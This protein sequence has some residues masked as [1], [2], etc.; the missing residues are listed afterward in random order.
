[1]RSADLRLAVFGGDS[2][3]RNRNKEDRFVPIHGTK[4]R[5]LLQSLPRGSELV[6]VM[7]DGKAVSAEELRRYLKRL[8]G[9]CG[10]AKP[11]QY[12][13]HTFRRFFASCCSRQKLSYKYILEWRGHSSG[14]VLDVSFMMNDRQA[15]PAMNSL[16]FD[17]ENRTVP[18]Q[19]GVHFSTLQAQ[20]VAQ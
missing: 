12:K 9:Q 4:L 16:S 18:G 2:N 13:L 20:V 14:G 8:C 17:S 15:Q 11:G 19:S 5:P 3:G 10:F 6:F 7:P 1:V